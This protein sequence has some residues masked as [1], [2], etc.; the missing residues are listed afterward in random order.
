MRPSL[1]KL[2][3]KYSVAAHIPNLLRRLAD[4]LDM[5]IR[6]RERINL[7]RMLPL[8]ASPCTSTPSTAWKTRKRF[9]GNS[10]TPNVAGR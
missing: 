9:E 3:H 10:S 5:T 8:P 6:Y 7:A 2:R 4:V 1:I